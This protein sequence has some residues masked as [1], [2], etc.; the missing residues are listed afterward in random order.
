MAAGHWLDSFGTAADWLE[1]HTEAT[2]ASAKPKADAHMDGC[3][4]EVAAK[5]ATP[6]PNPDAITDAAIVEWCKATVKTN[7]CVGKGMA[8]GWRLP[9]A[10]TVANNEANIA[11]ADIRLRDGSD[12]TRVLR[13][14]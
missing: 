1:A 8:H 4:P 10:D 6:L 11:C 13:L 2:D 14:S 12:L 9:P 7:I 5:H 3:Q